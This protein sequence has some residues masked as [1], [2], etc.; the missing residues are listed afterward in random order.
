MTKKWVL[1]KIKKKK[2]S[3]LCAPFGASYSYEKW[4]L[5]L[6]IKVDEDEIEWFEFLH[7][8]NDLTGKSAV[9]FGEIVMCLNWIYKDRL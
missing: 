5:E 7:D 9:T 8:I 3:W 6:L 1:L 4:F 2:K